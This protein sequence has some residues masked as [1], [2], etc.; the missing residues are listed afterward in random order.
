MTGINEL[1]GVDRGRDVKDDGDSTSQ[2]E[3][4]DGVAKK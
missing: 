1:Y 4:S 2:S 3:D